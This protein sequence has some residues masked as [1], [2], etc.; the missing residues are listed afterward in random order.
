MGGHQ[1]DLLAKLFHADLLSGE[2]PAEI[3]LATT[4]ADAAA[5]ADRQ[6]A[7]MEG[8]FQ[9]A[10]TLILE[11]S[12][13]PAKHSTL[14]QN[15]QHPSRLAAHPVIGRPVARERTIASARYSSEAPACARRSMTEVS[16]CG[17]VAPARCA[18]ARANCRETVLAYSMASFASA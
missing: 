15:R 8:I 9:L 13:K 4:D 2:H 18:A 1:P 10:R 11:V 3:D 12:V 17:L 5:V 7:V 16:T 14:V 6:G